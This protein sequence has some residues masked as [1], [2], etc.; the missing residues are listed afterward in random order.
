[1]PEHVR[2]YI[3]RLLTPVAALLIFYGVISEAE[4]A[5]WVELAGTA[6]L[7]GEGALAARHTTTARPEP[8][9]GSEG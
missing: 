7:V 2:A 5:L 3:Y 9:S 1:M 8:T 4:A 6:L